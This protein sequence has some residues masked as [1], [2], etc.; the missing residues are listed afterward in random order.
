MSLY[1]QLWLSIAILMLLAFLGSFGIGTLT[2]KSNMER[3]LHIKNIDNANNLALAA[4]Q[5][6]DDHTMVEL[7]ISAQFDSGHYQRLRYLSP[8][9]ETIIELTR[10]LATS[11][12]AQWFQRIFSI[13][14]DVAVAS[15]QAGWKQLG[16]IEVQSDPSFAY[17]AVWNTAL[18]LL[19]YFTAAALVFGLIGHLI[20]KAITTPLHSVVEQ[21][22]A[23]KNRRFLTVSLPR[24]LEFR[25]LVIAMNS[26]TDSIKY[27]FEE[28]SSQL[29]KMQLEN[30]IDPITGL[31]SREHFLMLMR[32]S[33]S[34]LEASDHG[35]LVIFRIH[36]L[37][38]LNRNEGRSIV[39]L[40]LKQFG[41]LLRN[42]STEHEQWISGR[43]NGSDFAVLAPDQKSAGALAKEVYYALLAKLQEFDLQ[44]EV[45][46]PTAAHQYYAN[47]SIA[48]TLS[49]VDQAL[50]LAES[51]RASNIEITYDDE[52][53]SSIKD[54]KYWQKIIDDII[55]G[56]K[57]EIDS[58]T[59]L[60]RD[61][62]FLYSKLTC[63]HAN[64]ENA[65]SRRQLYTWVAR[66][67][68]GFQF[69][70]AALEKMYTVNDQLRHPIAFAP[71][72]ITLKYYESKSHLPDNFEPSFPAGT[73]I[74]IPEYFAT[75]NFAEFKRICEHLHEKNYLIGLTG[76][77][78]HL[79]N[80]ASI[81]DCGIA[82]ITLDSTITM[83][84]QIS[85]RNQVLARCLAIMFHSIGTKVYADGIKTLEQWDLL[86]KLGIDGGSGPFVDIK[87]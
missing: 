31:H 51:K 83:D 78:L 84:I 19:M 66:L 16:E 37:Q 81:F 60:S 65:I 9:G 28:E 74:E 21:S 36:N 45:I 48:H 82:F 79:E 30:Q 33:L 23:L 17:Q 53:S 86:M 58:D 32:Q 71:S 55:D 87:Y 8:E 62:Q 1:K 73:C 70:H 69:D 72:P 61:G 42:L 24:T 35:S 44:D 26:L 25:E 13:K 68:R 52:S 29:I 18:N 22:H 41:E 6:A 63:S 47:E 80:M 11:I 77:G 4:S 50:C 43:L 57:L 2:I 20:L 54:S 27:F 7:L 3:Q 59:V 38:D 46:I 14:S 12:P 40:L 10:P 15:V 56:K 39:D 49:I 85:E 75:Q 67:Q 76:A 5:L 64:G 34:S